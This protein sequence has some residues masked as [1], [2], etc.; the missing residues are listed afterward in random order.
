MCHLNNCEQALTVS[1]GRLTWLSLN[2]TIEGKK[3]NSSDETDRRFTARLLCCERGGCEGLTDASEA[4]EAVVGLQQR[5][6]YLRANL[7]VIG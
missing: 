1:F 3:K 2:C 5:R 4:R 7:K 6:K